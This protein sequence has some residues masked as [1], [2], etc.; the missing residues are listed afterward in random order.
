MLIIAIVTV[1]VVFAAM[2]WPLIGFTTIDDGIW[3]LPGMKPCALVNVSK[4]I[5]P[6]N[7]I[8][9]AR[10]NLQSI[11]DSLPAAKVDEV[12]WIA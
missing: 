1:K 8:A 7:G 9:R 3:V 6:W 2:F 5:Y 10:N 12:V 4:G 11:R